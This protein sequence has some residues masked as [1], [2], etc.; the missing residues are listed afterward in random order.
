MWCVCWL[1]LSVWKVGVVIIMLFRLLG[2]IYRMW[3]V[4][5]YMVWCLGMLVGIM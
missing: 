3:F 5:V 4:L 1:V 2:C